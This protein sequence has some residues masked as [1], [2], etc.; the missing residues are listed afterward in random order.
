MGVKMLAFLTL[1]FV[2]QLVGEFFVPASG[3]PVPFPVLQWA[4]MLW[5]PLYCC[6]LSGD[7]F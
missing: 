3:L 7:G 4:S 1:I 5:L 2:C 6:R